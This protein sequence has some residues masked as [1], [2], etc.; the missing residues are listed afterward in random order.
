MNILYISHLSNRVA[1]GL[2]WSVPASVDAQSKID[3]VLWVDL[4]DAFLPHWGKVKAYHNIKEYGKLKLENFPAPFCHPD[5][6][7]FE[8]FY[9]PKDCF[10]AKVL[11][12][13][14]IP[15]I[16]VPRCSL[17]HQALNNHS[18]LKKKIAH[19]FLFDSFAHHAMAIQYLTPKE[20][21]DSSDKWNSNHLI[22]PNG[23]TTPDECKENFTVN[24]IKAIFIGRLDMYQKGLDILLEVILKCKQQ[25][26]EANF[27]LVLYGPEMHDWHKIAD[28]IQSHDLSAIVSMGGEVFGERKQQ[29][30][31]NADIMVMPSR[32]EGLPMG[33]L[34]TMAYGL[35][36]LV[37]VGTNMSEEVAKAG[38]GWCC[39]PTSDSLRKALLQM[40]TEKAEFKKRGKNAALLAKQYDWNVIAQKFHEQL[41]ALL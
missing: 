13:K 35:P 18:K 14:H 40:I 7:V 12:K 15:Y 26:L 1:S 31:I 28:Y 36:C 37:S 10:F 17:T 24:G 22:I 4:N 2:N 8:G 39:N 41:I 38:A 34:E 29:A 3:N 5:V 11:R 33:L 27:S 6:V 32:F 9:E 21:E 19:F 25:L 23:F 20:Y 16:I 30:I